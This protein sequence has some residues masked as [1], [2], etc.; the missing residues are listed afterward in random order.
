M[1]DSGGLS[2][3]YAMII[4]IGAPYFSTPLP[5]EVRYAVGEAGSITI[6]EV[7]DEDVSSGVTI[8]IENNPWFLLWNDTE[9]YIDTN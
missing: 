8:S 5:A 9:F 3:S 7:I 6:P 1:V 2:T 4:K